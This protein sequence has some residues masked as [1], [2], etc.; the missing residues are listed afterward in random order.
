MRTHM[1][2]IGENGFPAEEKIKGPQSKTYTHAHT[3]LASYCACEY[4]RDR[5]V[6]HQD[7]IESSEK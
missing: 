1:H 6:K 4:E 5:T 2:K 3:Q 7:K